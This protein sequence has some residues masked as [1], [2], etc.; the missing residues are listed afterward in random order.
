LRRPGHATTGHVF[1]ALEHHNNNMVSMMFGLTE[2]HH[3]RP[4]CLGIS[5]MR[6][7]GCVTGVPGLRAMEQLT[8]SEN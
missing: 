2:H 6:R 3:K 8:G 4:E 1:E 7:A 5:G